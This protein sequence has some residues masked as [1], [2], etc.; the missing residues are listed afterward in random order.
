MLKTNRLIALT[1]LIL[2]LGACQPTE[3]PATPDQTSNQ[4]NNQTAESFPIDPLFN[5]LY[6]YL[7]GEEVLGPAISPLI[8]SGELKSQYL[9]AG[10][11]TYDPRATESDRFQL[12]PI[13]LTL[14]VEEPPVPN[15]GVPGERYLNGHI[16][17][18]D[19]LPLYEQLGGARFVGQPLT[20]AHRNPET[21]RIEQYFENLGFFGVEGEAADQVHL[22]S[23]GVSACKER[24]RYASSPNSLPEQQGDL[25]EPFGVAA[26]QLGSNFTGRPLTQPV[27]DEDGTTEVIFENVVLIDRD[28]EKNQKQQ[29]SYNIILSLPK[30]LIDKVKRTSNSDQNHQDSS[31]LPTVAKLS[32]N[33]E[34]KAFVQLH[35][36]YRLPLLQASEELPMDRIDLRPLPGLLGIPAE[37]PIL[38]NNDPLMVF[39]PVKGNKGFQ[40]PWIFDEYIQAHGGYSFVGLP[41]GETHALSEGVFRQ[42]F[43]NICLDFKPGVE[44]SERLH[45]S[46]LGTEYNAV[47]YPEPAATAQPGEMEQVDLQVWEEKPYVAPDESQVI[48]VATS[49]NGEPLNGSNLTLTVTLPDGSQQVYQLQPTDATGRSSLS[50]P[51]LGAPSATIIPYEVCLQGANPGEK[52]CK[53]DNFLIWGSSK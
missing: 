20:E 25:P 46:P 26:T 52:P 38:P 15:P 21:G 40:V 30:F 28:S 53:S 3:I 39:I 31:W 37:N 33:P 9:E 29:F 11:M 43:T 24:C 19:F 50:L 14:G 27:V 47:V 49:L 16:I 35:S 18:P 2:L 44:G 7:G 8:E 6:T 34:N 1:V 5:D 22:L 10:L 42:C 23:Y 36:P 32:I 13:G 45:P 12:A 48:H 17:S 4:S 41:I 51:P